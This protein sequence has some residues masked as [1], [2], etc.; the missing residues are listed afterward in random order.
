MSDGGHRTQLRERAPEP[1]TSAEMCR[2][3][4]PRLATVEVLTQVMRVPEVEVPDLWALDAHNAE[5]V[6]CRHLE[7]LRFPRRHRELGDF[8]HLSPCLAVKCGPERW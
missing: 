1:V 6:A 8:G 5:E 2:V 7:R 3:Q 4:S